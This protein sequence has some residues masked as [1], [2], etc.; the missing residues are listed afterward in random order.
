MCVFRVGLSR[1][2]VLLTGC[3][4]DQHGEPGWVYRYCPSVV[5]LRICILAEGVACG[6][7]LGLKLLLGRMLTLEVYPC[8]SL[9]QAE[10]VP[11]L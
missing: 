6:S 4:E 8:L 5:L 11:G 7:L 3:V 1:C 9:E 10:K 2:T